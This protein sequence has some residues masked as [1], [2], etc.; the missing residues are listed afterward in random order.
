MTATTNF[1]PV[2]SFDADGNMTEGPV[3]GAAGL[4]PGVQA[5]TGATDLLWDAE[6][7]LVGATVGTSTLSYTHDHLS[8]LVK[9]A[10]TVG[11]TTTIS[12]HNKASQQS[13][14]PLLTIL[15][16]WGADPALCLRCNTPMKTIG[17]VR[18]PEKVEF[19][20][21]LWGLWA[22]VINIPPQKPPFDIETFEPITPP[23]RA[24]K[25]WVPGDEPPDFWDK[26]AEFPGDW[27]QCRNPELRETDLGDGRILP[28]FD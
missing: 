27:N 26:T 11:G 12:H 25:E 18:R 20:L 2:P 8:R 15:Q 5:P 24:I 7:R 28:W 13:F 19:F 16:V 9:R 21:R 3:T 23:E 1:S 22:G 10:V 14:C 6:N 4:S 17:G